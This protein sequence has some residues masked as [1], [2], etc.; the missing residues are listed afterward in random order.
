MAS[1]RSVTRSSGGVAFDPLELSRTGTAA[2][3]GGGPAA[4]G[5]SSFTGFSPP[6]SG[7]H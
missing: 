2:V 3:V 1:T 7:I 5:G 6:M 4:F